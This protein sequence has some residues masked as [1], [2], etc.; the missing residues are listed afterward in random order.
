[1]TAPLRRAL[2]SLEG[3]SV[4]DAFG[5]QFFRHP[6]EALP[7]IRRREDP[8]GGNW[9]WTDDT[10]MAL[11]IVAV[12][13]RAGTIDQS[14]LARAFGSA[15]AYDPA[16]GYG[17]GMHRL[18]IR[19]KEGD[20]WLWLAADQF[21]GQGSF[22]N[23]AAMRVAPLGAF[24][25]GDLPRVAEEATKSAEVTHAHPEGI[26]G[27]IAIAVATSLACT[28]PGLVGRAFIDAVQSQ[29]PQSAVQSG[30]IRA[31][32]VLQE[33]TAEQ[34]A[35]MLGSGMEVSAQDTVPFC[36]WAASRHLD[37][38]EGA[39]WATVSGLGDRD[40]TCAIVGGI[41]GARLGVDG[42]PE[43]WRRSR[44]GL[45]PWVGQMREHEEG[46]G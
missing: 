10:T 43:R 25:A 40:T 31:R 30:L 37:D 39:M 26:A 41:L 32:E 17:P 8:S 36:L 35:A 24:F 28:E 23:G 29:V 1:M 4:G 27:A 3:L 2:D 46:A 7:M 18:L 16:R 42:I 34:A 20:E 13:E 22:G 12:L 45:P 14:L 9:H 15:Y 5:E 44:E 38:Y 6:D 33:T 19:Y 11:S 21:G